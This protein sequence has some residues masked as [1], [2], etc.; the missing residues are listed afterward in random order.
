MSRCPEQ[1]GA[2]GLMEVEIVNDWKGIK[3]TS[4]EAENVLQFHCGVGYMRYILIICQNPLNQWI[5]FTV[6]KLR[7]N[8]VGLKNTKSW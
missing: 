6:C 5:H 4:G 8:K 3:E 2:L 1:E 7:L